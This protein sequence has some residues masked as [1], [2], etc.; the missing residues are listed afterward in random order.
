MSDEDRYSYPPFSKDHFE[1]DNDDSR[2]SAEAGDESRMSMLGPKMRIHGR[3]PW[4]MGEDMLEE[5]DESDSSG[6]SRVFSG[7]RG[8]GKGIK[9]F[10]KPKRPSHESSRSAQRTKGSFETTASSVSNSQGP[11]QCVPI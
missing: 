7:K 2:G 9:G 8:K 11:L 10:G 3:A 5:A 4:E 6:K 1:N